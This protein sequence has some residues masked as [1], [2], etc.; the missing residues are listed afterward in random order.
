MFRALLKKETQFRYCPTS[1]SKLW[2]TVSALKQPIWIPKSPK[3]STP[4]L[5]KTGATTAPPHMLY[6]IVRK[7]SD[8][9]QVEITFPDEKGQLTIA[10]G[11]SKFALSTT[12][13][14]ELSGYF[15]RQT[16]D[17]LCN[18]QRRIERRYRPDAVCGFNGRN[19]ILSQRLVCSRQERRGFQRT[20]RG[21]Y[22]RP[23]SGMRRISV[24]AGRR[25]YERR[26][27]SAQNSYRNP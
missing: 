4:K 20:A 22:R 18:G 21:S 1:E 25:R 10:S 11:R 17:Q 24:A 16:A 26:Y 5:A 14:E 2:A 15:R 23:P 6:D 8:G 27:Y 13:V 19:Q 7:L 3:S 12:G 9:S